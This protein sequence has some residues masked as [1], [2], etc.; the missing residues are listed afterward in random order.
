MFN[1]DYLTLYLHS[2]LVQKQS[3][4][5]LPFSLLYERKI[6][7]IYKS[8]NFSIPADTFMYTVKVWKI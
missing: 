1:R 6:M 2:E 4:H 5:L 8:S 7:T 3:N